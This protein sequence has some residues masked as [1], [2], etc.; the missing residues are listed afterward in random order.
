MVTEVEELVNRLSESDKKTLSL[1]ISA[2][3][4]KPK[5]NMQQVMDDMAAYAKKQGLNSDELK[6]LLSKE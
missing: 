4:A 1:L 2:F 6:D 3:V 5:R